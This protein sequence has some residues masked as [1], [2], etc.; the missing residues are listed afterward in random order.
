MLFISKGQPEAT[1]RQTSRSILLAL[2]ISLP[3]PIQARAAWLRCSALGTTESGPREFFTTIAEVGPLPPAALQ[4]FQSKL[5]TYARREE[6]TIQGVQSRCYSYDD[7][8]EAVTATDHILD[9]EARRIG[10]EHMT[11]VAPS[12]WLPQSESGRDIYHP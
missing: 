10:W 12:D 8:V 2:C 7:Q 1:L 9:N 6:P 11:I 4:L 3:V 5:S